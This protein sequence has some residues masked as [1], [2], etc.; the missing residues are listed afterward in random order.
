MVERSHVIKHRI[1]PIIAG[2]II[3]AIALTL[4]L[5]YTS[6]TGPFQTS[7]STYVGKLSTIINEMRTIDFNERQT[8]QNWQSGKLTSDEV[9]SELTS[10]QAERLQ[11]RSNLDSLTPQETFREIHRDIFDANELWINAN[12]GYLQ[13][14]IQNNSNI[15]AD[16]D[17][18][19]KAANQ[20]FNSAIE[21]L[22]VLGYNI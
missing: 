17:T 21:K 9:V 15:I 16:A 5:S 11:V 7:E 12:D 13:G 20:K 10:L 2:I 14:I 8:M 18:K 4:L 19:E 3:I 6:L 1:L 22:G